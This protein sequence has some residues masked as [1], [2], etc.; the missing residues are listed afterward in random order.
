MRPSI[1]L[2]LVSLLVAGACSSS[3]SRGADRAAAVVAPRVDMDGFHLSTPAGEIDFLTGV[4]VG[5]AI[6]GRLPAELKIEP[7]TWRRWFPMIAALGVDAIRVYTVQP[8]SF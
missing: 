1:I 5:S 8:P 7:E 6:P 4:N 3:G 2:V